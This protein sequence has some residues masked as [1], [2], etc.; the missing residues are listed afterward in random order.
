MRGVDDPLGRAVQAVLYRPQ[1]GQQLI[2]M[3]REILGERLAQIVVAPTPVGLRQ[4]I[5]Q[6]GICLAHPVAEV[7]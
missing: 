5:T 4:A 7:G 3:R 6:S 1:V 2:G